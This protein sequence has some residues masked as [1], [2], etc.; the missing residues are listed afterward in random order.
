MAHADPFGLQQQ[1]A[2]AVHPIAG[3][4]ARHGQ[5]AARG[6]AKALAASVTSPPLPPRRTPAQ[7]LPAPLDTLIDPDC[8]SDT[9]PL[10]RNA[11]EPP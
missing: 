2:A 1:L 3:D 8:V 10:L 11:T 9:S 5:H 4:L 7:D 6:V